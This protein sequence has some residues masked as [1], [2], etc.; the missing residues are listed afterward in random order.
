VHYAHANLVVHR[1]LKPSNILVTADG[2][3]KLLDFGI[4]KALGHESL[5][6][7]RLSLAGQRLMTPEYAA[8]E[9]VC[10][11]AVTA[12][13]DVYSL[14]AV[15]YELLSGRRVHHLERRAPGE[16]VDVL[17]DVEPEPPSGA[18]VRPPPERWPSSRSWPSPADVAEQRG[19]TPERLRRHL[20]EG[21][22]SIV[23]KALA[24]NPAQRYPS[25]EALRDDLERTQ[26]ERAW[27]SGAE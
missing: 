3:V 11:E 10:G 15:L 1:D 23:L 7:P 19:T 17:C 13:T 26:S 5:M 16:I 22:D 14:A 4:A 25:A 9:Q 8:P 18:V 12:A 6:Q 21:L 20:T 2:V 27:I 24:K